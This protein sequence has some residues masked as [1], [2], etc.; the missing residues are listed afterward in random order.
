[1]PALIMALTVEPILALYVIVLRMVQNVESS[2]ITP[3]IQRRVV[4][5]SLWLFSS[6]RSSSCSCSAACSP[7]RLQ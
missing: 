6:R 3:L 4:A 5:R 2:I 1:M 7:H